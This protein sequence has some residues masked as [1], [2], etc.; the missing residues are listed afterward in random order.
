[1][2]CR[3]TAQTKDRFLSLLAADPCN[4]ARV[5]TAFACYAQHPQMA[6]FYLADDTAAL[7]VLDGSLLCCGSVPDRQELASFCA[8]AGITAAEGA[9]PLPGF[10][11]NEKLLCCRAADT[12]WQ[13]ATQIPTTLAPDLW[14][15]R[16]AALLD[17]DPDRWY[18]DA[19]LR[20]RADRA[21]IAA[22]EYDGKYIATAGIYA[23][24]QDAAY[25]SG[26][27]TRADCRGRGYAAALVDALCHRVANRS[28]YLLCAPALVPFYEKLGFAVRR[29]VTEYIK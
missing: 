28:V 14:Q 17:A 15:L 24:N 7:L 4:G 27:A 26:V 19:C 3:V 13:T 9:G 29:T 21:V 10:K 20:T 8:F 6:S 25:L 5:E 2:I 11:V 22:A 12:S 16:Q 1:M 23:M 18:A